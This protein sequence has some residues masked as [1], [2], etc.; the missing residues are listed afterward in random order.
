MGD[1]GR[2]PLW[3]APAPSPGGRYRCSPTQEAQ[4]LAFTRRSPFGRRARRGSARDTNREPDEQDG[5]VARLTGVPWKR[6]F[7]Y[8]RP[9][10]RLFAVAV[11][12]LLISTG[13]GLLLPLVIGSLVNEVVSAGDAA[14]LDLALIHI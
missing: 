13:F 6:L 3:G 8:L 7:G 10:L 12:A 2:A 4:P 1:R 14:G 9:N 11:V 5:G